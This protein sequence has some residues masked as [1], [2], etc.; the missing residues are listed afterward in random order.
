MSN[1]ETQITD[2]RKTSELTPNRE[3]KAYA[4]KF[5][6]ALPA[7]LRPLKLGEKYPRIVNT[8]AL[9]R[10]EPT[11]FRAYFNDLFVDTRGDR[12]GFPPDVAD[13]LARLKR[14]FETVVWSDA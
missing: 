6:A 13:E 3:L 12:Q 4:V 1:V 10:A 7:E 14:F 2:A 8:L 11:S 5:L 9:L